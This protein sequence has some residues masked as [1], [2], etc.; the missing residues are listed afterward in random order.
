[1]SVLNVER[2]R[3][4]LEDVRT[5]SPLPAR[6]NEEAVRDLLLKCLE[7]H[8]GSLDKC[9][10]VPGRAEGLLRQIKEM[11]EGGGF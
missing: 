1:M 11:I 5:R 2:K 6:P 8:Y 10:V 3:I 9:V 4:D 7:A